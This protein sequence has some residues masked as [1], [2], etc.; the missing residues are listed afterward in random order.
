MKLFNI[1]I[2]LIILF[3]YS[4]EELRASDNLSV[5]TKGGVYIHKIKKSDLNSDILLN[6]QQLLTI[7]YKNNFFLPVFL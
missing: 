3:T 7:E 2:F 4:T 1:Y 6:N 5:N